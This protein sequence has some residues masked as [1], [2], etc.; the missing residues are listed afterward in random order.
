MTSLAVFVVR[1]QRCFRMRWEHL[2][3][4]SHVRR[5]CLVICNDYCLDL[6]SP[7]R[8]FGSVWLGIELAALQ[9]SSELAGCTSDLILD[10]R[11]TDKSKNKTSST[12]SN[13]FPR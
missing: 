8:P 9:K 4:T 6:I 5:V 12:N 13:V 3:Y 11:V 7:Q 2:N 1:P 10:H